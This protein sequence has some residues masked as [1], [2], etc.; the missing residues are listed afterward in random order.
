V[1][2]EYQSTKLRPGARSSDADLLAEYERECEKAKARAEKFGT[3]YKQPAPDAFL[4]W[5]EARK[6]RA[7]PERGFITGIDVMSPEEQAKAADRK[8]RFADDN[9]KRKKEGDGDDIANEEEGQ[10]EPWQQE[11]EPLPVEQAWDNGDL[12]TSQRI[13]PPEHL[14]PA[15]GDVQN[16]EKDEMGENERASLVPEKIHLFSIDWAAFKQIRSDDVMAHFS[17]YGPSYV[18]WLGELSCNVHFEDKY[19]ASRALAALS[20]ELPSPVPEA[21]KTQQHQARK[22]M[23]EKG[24]KG[25]KDEKMEETDGKKEDVSTSK[26]KETNLV[27]KE[28]E[29][30]S[31]QMPLPDLGQMGWRFG[32]HPVRKVSNDKFGRRGTKA[33]FLLRVATSD[34]MLV[35]R[36][37]ERPRPPPGFTTKR[38]L[39]PGS[40]YDTSWRR[41]RGRGGKKKMA[42]RQKKGGNGRT[43]RQSRSDGENWQRDRYQDDSGDEPWQRDKY[44]GDEDDE[45]WE[46]DEGYSDDEDMGE[47]LDQGCGDDDKEDTHGD[48]LPA[49]LDRGLKA[50]RPG[51]SVEEMEKEREAKKAAAM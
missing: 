12:V 34:D 17:E 22:D 35:E 26:A 29:E 1:W 5:S 3:E 50:A 23:K 13:D 27:K 28:G 31:S 24:G 44:E 16:M 36:P 11:R 18:E 32:L 48:K 2:K 8:A 7:N 41:G 40:D 14:Y 45:E 6:L 47:E 46:D 20:R 9:N 25:F 38:V 21:V 4:K 49:G 33:R 30:E 43:K 15:H 19:S 39:G 42:K 51:F 37:T 10:G